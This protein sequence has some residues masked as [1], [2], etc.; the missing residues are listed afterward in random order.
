MLFPSNHL[1]LVWKVMEKITDFAENQMLKNPWKQL[2]AEKKSYEAKIFR[3][4]N[5]EDKYL[6]HP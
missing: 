6:Q 5:Y 1:D 2:H 3:E 4:T